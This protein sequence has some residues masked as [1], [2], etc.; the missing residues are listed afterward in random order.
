MYDTNHT[1]ELP[2][3]LKRVEGQQPTG[4]ELQYFARVFYWTIGFIEVQF[5]LCLIFLFWADQQ[6]TNAYDNAGRC[7]N[8]YK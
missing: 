7:Y 1:K 2:G 5:E 4:G 8:F 3:D 6:V